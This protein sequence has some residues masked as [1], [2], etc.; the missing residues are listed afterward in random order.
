[1]DSPLG[2][3][4]APDLIPV[5]DRCPPVDG[6]AG[7]EDEHPISSWVGPPE[8]RRMNVAVQPAVALEANPTIGL[9]A[10]YSRY[11]MSFS[12]SESDVLKAGELLELL[13]YFGRSSQKAGALAAQLLDRFGSLGAVVAAEP[14]KLVQALDGDGTSAI[15]LKA[16]RAS[17]KAILREPI[18]ERPVIST[19]S[20]LMDYL[21]VTMRHETTEST[22]ILFLDRK[23]ALIKDELHNRGT[24]DHTPLY[25]REVV[26]RVVEL[27]ASAVILVH[28]HPSGDPT[29]SQG[30]IEM[31]HRLAAALGTINVLL[32]DHVI[33]GRN[34]ETSLRKLK[35]I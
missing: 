13:L 16:V 10:G 32:H 17:V 3:T 31:T 30:D 19:A 7:L 21:S 6:S 8:H 18:E 14:T 20:A 4:G 26:K 23:N 22:R 33:V 28:N 34:R 24:I 29:P 11:L 25:P 9:H 35:L 2:R 5:D 27:G 15:L 12:W 1:M